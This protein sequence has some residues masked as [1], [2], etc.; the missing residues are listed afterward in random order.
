MVRLKFIV[1]DWDGTLV[2]SV[3]R[4]TACTQWTCRDLGLPEPSDAHVRDSIGL[5]LSQF[6]RNMAPQ[7]ES[8]LHREMEEG[9]RERWRSGEL[10]ESK[11]F[12]G[13]RTMLANLR[14]REFKLAVATGKSRAG[15]DREM[16]VHELA[17][18]F[19]L[20]RCA[21]ETR[22]KPNPDMLVEL[23]SELGI[24]AEETLMVGDS[25]LDME[26]AMRAG[27]HRFGVTSGCHDRAR[28]ARW[29]PRYC[30]PT[31]RDLEQWLLA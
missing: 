9:Y 20:T 23:M 15:L 1:F 8:S 3:G 31:V 19:D 4:I 25:E 6:M 21:D 7:G 18:C 24:E 13:V 2:D 22:P 28:L 27:A 10:T 11:L 30:A 26:M 17:S 29:I 16:D 5:D 14:E 12:D